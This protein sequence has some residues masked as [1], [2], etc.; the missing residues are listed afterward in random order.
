[1]QLTGTQF[2]R[3]AA[4]FGNDI[5]TLPDFPAEIRAPAGSLPGVSGFQISF[6]STDIHTPGDAAG[7]P[8][9]DEPG[10]AQDEHHATCRRAA[11]S[12]STATRSRQQNLNKAAY[13]SNPL[14]DGSLRGY[15][16]FESPISHAQR[17]LA[18]R[19]RHDEQAEGP[20]EELLRAGAHVLAV[21]A[22]AGA[23]AR[24]D[25]REVRAR[26]D[27]R[28]G[29]QAGAQGRLRL[30]RDDRDLP[31][32]L[33]RR[34]AQLP[35]GTYRNITGNEATALGFVA[36]SKLARR[37][38]FYGSYPIT[39]AS[40]ILHQLSTLQDVRRQDLP[41]RGRDRGHRR[42]HR[43][44]LRRGARDDRHV[45]PGHRAQDRGD[46]PRG[47]G[48]A[49]ARRHRRPA[50]RPVDRACRRRPSRRT[51]SRSCSAAT[52]TRRPDRRAGDA[53][54]LLRHGDRGVADRAQVHDPGRLPLRRLP[55]H[56]LGAVADPGPRRPAG[57]RRSTTRRR[58]DGPFQPYLRDP[59]TLARPW[60]VP[61]TAGLEH[62]IGGLEKADVTGNVSYD[63]D[64]HHKM[65]LLRAARSPASPKDIAAARGLRPDDAATLLILGWGSTYGAIRTAV[66]R[67]HAE[68]RSV[69]HAHLRH[70]NPFPANTE[71]VL[72]SLPAGAH[73]G[74]QPRPAP[75]AHPGALPHRRGRLRPVRGKP[76]RIAEI[77][78]EAERVLAE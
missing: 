39:P 40:D 20:H 35:P 61:G 6:S 47:H 60:A 27:R 16:V 32:A 76:F 5:S 72:R 77:V 15:R 25:R 57:H 42:G 53:G 21:R 38:L 50:R 71:E 78:D 18:R 43:R 51:C 65:Q 31:H 54:R 46:R 56:R 24:L 30:R 10:G 26:P 7:R 45:R 22:A 59:E 37:P 11:P 1:M 62:R 73:P 34:P 48:R 70:L 66:E 75:D 49:A 44:E 13:A 3:T 55:R 4:V 17:A 67:L 52:A 64:N 19:A 8:R 28:R 9:R 41:G 29:Q 63:P 2:T 68:G 58:G 33:P 74:G 23:D 12:S 14:T 69:A 36:A